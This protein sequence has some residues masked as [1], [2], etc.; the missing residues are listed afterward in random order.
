MAI[1]NHPIQNKPVQ[2]SDLKPNSHISKQESF[3]KANEKRHVEKV[4][5]GEVKTRKRPIG[6]KFADVFLADDVK[7]VK[8]YLFFDVL[9]PALKTLIVDMV[10]D[11]VEMMLWGTTRGRRS[12]TGGRNESTAYNTYYKSGTRN[13]R[14]N[15]SSDRN[16]RADYRDL[17][18]ASR[19]EAEDV[20]S[21]LVDLT[22]SEYE[23]ASIADLY[24]AAG[25]SRPGNFTDEKWGWTDMGRANVRRVRDGYLLELPKAQPLD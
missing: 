23:A 22:T 5:T 2:L 11:S 13:D 9:V 18:F 25:V 21:A 24:D 3:E 12:R 14:R 15:D 10:S 16:S 19:E 17:I 6:Q 4:V 1:V 8:G 7:T 20:L